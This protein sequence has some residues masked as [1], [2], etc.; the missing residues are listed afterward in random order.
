[1]HG[2]GETYKIDVAEFKGAAMDPYTRNSSFHNLQPQ[3]KLEP[4]RPNP[5]FHPRRMFGLKIT[6]DPGALVGLVAVDKG[7]YVLNNKFRLTQ[8][9]ATYD[10]LLIFENILDII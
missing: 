5:S 9:K 4:S 7:V 6:G 10:S 3:L 1:M 2:H 8:K